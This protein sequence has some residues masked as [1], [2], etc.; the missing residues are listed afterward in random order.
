MECSIDY[1][2]G[3]GGL[4][5]SEFLGP[6]NLRVGGKKFVHDDETVLCLGL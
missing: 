6:V 5:V 4:F 1:W 3:G 2:G